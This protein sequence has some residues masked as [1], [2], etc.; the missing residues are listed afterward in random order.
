MKLVFLG[1][2][3]SYPSPQRNV[4]STALK[5]KGDVLLFDCG[6]GT[7]RQLMRSSLSFMETKKI[8]ITH[9]H[10]DHFLGIPGL[11]QS[12]KLNDREDPLEIYGPKGM[13][14][15]T[16]ILMKLGYFNPSFE[17]KIQDINPG[18]EL[19]FDDYTI[20]AVETDH[21][22]PSLAYGFQEKTKPGRFDKQ[23][24]LDLGVPEGPLF[25]RIQKGHT[26]EVD[27]KTIRPEQ[28]LG[29]P[30]R[31]KKVVFS[32]D[33]RPSYE[34]IQLAEE[35]D[36]LVHEA[37][38]DR[39]MSDKAIEFGHS[40][41]DKAAEVAKKA[42]VKRLFLNHI[43]PRYKD[44]EPLKEQAKEIFEKTVIP[45]DLDEYEI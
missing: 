30:R 17:V 40:S 9:F 23:K 25:S 12:M 5:Y 10:G 19:R 39:S 15:L 7:Q 27:G 33:T 22:I 32:G 28:I 8:F 43:S 3:G 42:R 1:T 24:A 2:G 38:L 6:E 37:T 36:V 16:T 45:D 21:G 41:V 31:G 26:V 14:D 11:I 4:T 44:P 13:T 29:P 35:A 20:K 18:A 34:V